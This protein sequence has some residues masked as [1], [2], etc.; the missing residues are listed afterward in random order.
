MH[1]P[2]EVE[3]QW[4]LTFLLLGGL[5]FVG[6]FNVIIFL[7][8]RRLKVHYYFGMLCIFYVIWYSA[9]FATLDILMLSDNQNM[10][11]IAIGANRMAVHI[12]LY[13]I[14]TLKM[15]N[16]IFE[17]HFK[18]ISNLLL[19]ACLFIPLSFVY[20]EGLLWSIEL[21]NVL[22]QVFISYKIVV[23]MKGFFKD[24]RFIPAIIYFIITIGTVMQFINLEATRNTLILA[25]FMMAIQAIILSLHYNKMIVEVEQSNMTLESK[26]RERTA[27]LLEKEKETIQLISSI[28][29]DLRT[30]ITVIGGY[31]GL[32]KGDKSSVTEEHRKYIST[33]LVRLSQMEKLTDDLFTLAKVSDRNYTFQLEALD[34][35]GMMEQLVP[36]YQVQAKE[37]GITLEVHT[38]EAVFLAD[39]VRFLQVIDNL[40]INAL[41]YAHSSITITAVVESEEVLF[42]VA[43]DGKG[44]DS[45][46]IPF[47]FERFFKKSK[48]GS[49]L[50]LSNVKELI[51]RMSGTV[52][53]ESKLNMGTKF[54][55]ILPLANKNET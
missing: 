16:P 35:E 43:D 19:L 44:I 31:L 22:I 26:V 12:T 28:S 54:Y 51:H 10:M 21:F 40:M 32:L 39:E 3:M 20:G 13:T 9:K 18:I 52:G 49:G 48:Y 55:F 29:H 34:L 47:V 33:S 6:L 30:P 11:L 42:S 2:F 17:K 41:E 24:L 50:G 4:V 14:Y 53:V 27:N 8:R 36:L 1:I 15:N 25:F 37:K 5:L 7:I 38:E 23:F 46:D 45:A